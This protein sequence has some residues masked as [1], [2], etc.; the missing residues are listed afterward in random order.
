MTLRYCSCKLL[1]VSFLCKGRINVV[2]L[3]Q[4]SCQPDLS[5]IVVIIYSFMLCVLYQ[6]LNIDLSHIEAK[7]GDLLKHD[8]SLTLLQGELI[9]R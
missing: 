2:D 5:T 1:I 8:Q 6:L 9:G 3:Q 7:I 4:V